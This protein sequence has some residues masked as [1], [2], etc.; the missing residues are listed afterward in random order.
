MF[1][2]YPYT[3]FHEMNLDWIIAEMKDL[4]D[5]WDSFGGNVTATAHEASNPE[6]TVSGDLKTGLDFDFGLVR[7][8]RGATGSQGPRGE[9]GPAGNGL[10]IL[11]IYPT[12]EALQSAH[13]TGTPGDAYLI[14]SDRNY[15]LYIWS[16]SASAWSDG[17]SL[18]SPAPSN[19]APVMDGVAAS[20]SSQLYSRSDHVHPSDTAK[21]DKATGTGVYAANNGT[22][23]MLGYADNAVPDALVQYDSTGAIN[24]SNVNVS[25]NLSADTISVNNNT[26]LNSNKLYGV[27]NASN[28]YQP[29]T[30]VSASTPVL[31]IGE[32]QTLQTP[33]VKF[34]GTKFAND[35]TSSDATSEVHF[36]SAFKINDSDYQQSR[37]DLNPA[38]AATL[39]G[40]KIGDGLSVDASGTV[41]SVAVIKSGDFVAAGIYAPEFFGFLATEHEIDLTIPLNRYI[42]ASSVTIPKLQISVYVSGNRVVNDT[43]IIQ[44]ANYTVTAFI[45]RYVGIVLRIVNNNITFGNARELAGVVIR[46]SDSGFQFS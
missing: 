35:G 14:G 2:K 29:L 43:D 34:M 46:T 16:A 25:A 41:S 13:P 12:L 33:S 28:A 5:S 17:G 15:T 3:S 10:E 19:N 30:T 21:L 42:T 20:G 18:T 24:A 31:G 44:D 37:I 6:V 9:Q 40:V 36:S 22:Q 11:D 38:T 32:D 23:T 45:E 27:A 4:V 39:G 7:G 1:D 8:P 26:I